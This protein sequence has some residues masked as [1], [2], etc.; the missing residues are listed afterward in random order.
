MSLMSSDKS[1]GSEKERLKHKTVIPSVG[2]EPGLKHSPESRLS[3]DYRNK[4]APDLR[5][6]ELQHNLCPP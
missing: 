2:D 6:T 3:S 1:P 4:A 5:L